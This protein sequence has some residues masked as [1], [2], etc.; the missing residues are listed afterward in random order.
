MKP[1][2]CLQLLACLST[3]L[4]IFCA[5]HDDA[6][7]EQSSPSDAD[8]SEAPDAYHDKIREKPYPKADN[9]LY[10]NPAPLIVPQAMK[11]DA[12]LQFA[13]SRS[14]NFDTP[15]TVTSEAV[16]WCMFNPHKQLEGG[17]W[18]WRFRNITADGAEGAWSEVYPFEVE[19]TTPVFVTPSF[20]TFRQNAPHTYPRLYCFL[21]DRI[22]VARQEVTSHTEYQRLTNNAADALNAD[23]AAIGN[24][25][26]QIEVVKGYI[27]SLYQA[28]YLTRQ[29]A[30]AKRLHELLQLLTGTPVS[31]ATLFADNF[32]STDIAFCFLKPY[33]LLYNRLTSGERQSVEE[34]LMRVLRYYY[35]QQCGA[36][37]NHIFDNHFWQQN[38]RIL[39]QSA[40]LLYDNDA[41]KD[42]VVP[43]ME[44]YYE[45]WTARAPASGFNRDGVWHNGTGYFNNNVRTLSYMPML[46]SY[47]THKDFLLHPW[48]QHAGQSLAF[49]CP[50]ESKNI[51][52][53]DGSEKYTAATY[54]YAAFADFLARE[55]GDGY[56]GWY[57]RQT[58]KTLLRD[59]DMRLYRMASCGIGY[60]TQLPEETPKLVWYK[61]AGEVAMHSNLAN[62][63]EDLAL[64]FRSSTFGSGSHTVSNQNAFNLLYRGTDVYRSSGYYTNFSDAHNLMSYRHTRAHNTI[65]VNGIGQPFSTEAYGRIVRAMGG[66][67][68]SYC[69]GDA[70]K[71]YS[72]ISKDL[73]WVKAF[74][75][76]GI[77][78]TPEN[79]F[80]TTPLTRYRRHVLMLH[81][82]IVVIYD[83]MEASEKVRWEWLLHSDTP[84]D[85]D[86]SNRTLTTKNTVKN[87]STVT[88][89][90][91]NDVPE[92]TQTDQFVV[93]PAGTPAPAYP[94][95]WHLT[96]RIEGKEKTRI[97]AI[98]QVK[99]DGDA[100]EEV[101]FD[102]HS[103]TCGNWNIKAELDSSQPAALNISHKIK[104]CIFS[105]SP[106]NPVI[107][108]DVYVRTYDSSSLLYDKIDGEYSIVEQQ[109][110]Q[111]AST[112]A[113]Y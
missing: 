18:Y 101:N 17:T 21:D 100:S 106:E 22:Q 48:Y 65:L 44:Y 107:E 67:H 16:A 23:L 66:G 85:I 10:L 53:G 11:T 105:Y 97:L 41:Y 33:D 38:L 27:Q 63:E 49:T 42:E 103:I 71:A 72:G 56:A 4:L 102:G 108:G 5:C 94:N 1:S 69:L 87:F 2:S 83:E 40:F 47:I 61:D 14:K 99:N 60:D 9:E 50:P 75:A 82:D 25:Y 29:E 35:P 104:R 26:R 93:P 58:A 7:P 57:A 90:F 46:L 68:I 34:L 31:D 110:Y 91:S 20:E 8:N 43:I 77:A 52:F 95:Q 80:G 76:A 6:M 88:R 62:T 78:Q 81:P 30:Y 32:G 86:A 59:S 19:D 84:F 79:G 15:E 74:E 96:A 109:D 28:Y 55:T 92:L 37:E 54:Q 64:A 3:A 98:I 24:P 113:G 36:Q 112:R 45:L 73:M 70:S 89:I 13:L 111:M 12:K 51:G 39:F